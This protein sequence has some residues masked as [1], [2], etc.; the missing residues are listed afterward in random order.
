MRSAKELHNQAMD[1]VEN[2]ILE[3]IRGNAESTS[4]LYAKALELELDAIADLEE[5]GHI[6]E[7]TW[8]VLHRGAGWMAFNS[9]QYRRAEKL[10]SKALAGDPHP[11]IVEELRDLWEQANFHLHLEPLDIAMSEEEVQ[12]SLMGRAV[13]SGTV[14]LSELVSR[15]T[16]FQ[17]LAYRIV[18]RRL[19]L[20]YQ[21][22]VPSDIRNGYPAFAAAPRPGSFIISL[23]LGHPTSQPSLPGFLGAGEVISEIIDLMDLADRSQ[24]EEI[25]R[26]IPD[27]SYQR[28]FFGLAKNLAPDGKRIRRV[29]FAAIRRGATKSISVTTPASQ[30]PVPDSENV[31]NQGQVEVSGRLRYADGSAGS[32]SN[33]RIR[34]IDN[35]IQHTVSVPPGLM[36]DIV[37]PLWNSFVTVKGTRRK[38]QRIIR[39]QDIWE[40]DPTPDQVDSQRSILVSDS[41]YGNQSTMF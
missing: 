13:S 12:I 41:D 16:N 10:A 31:Q 27:S 24:V 23:R 39:L 37:R 30:F 28:N 19:Q 17:K 1:L 20:P 14:L 5:N 40:S 3:R 22:R 33:N 35:G 25:Q 4:Y 32:S 7:P 18:Q 11:E 6:E 29:G 9:G 15:V 2:A 26:R 8:S 38:N 21:A 36:D 34:L